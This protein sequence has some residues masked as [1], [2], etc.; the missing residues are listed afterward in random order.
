M[1]EFY[2]AVIEILEANDGVGQELDG[3]TILKNEFAGLQPESLM[4]R[5]LNETTLGQSGN[6]KQVEGVIELNALVQIDKRTSAAN[7]RETQEVAAEELANKV[8]KVLL[9]NDGKLISTSY[10]SGIT[11]HPEMTMIRNRTFGEHQHQDGE[12][13]FVRMELMAHYVY[14]DM[15]LA[16]Q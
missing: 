15:V 3:V 7:Y 13:V 2:N 12:F 9:D 1:K 10:V 11:K 6:Y 8:E 14:R 5:R 4:V 16:L